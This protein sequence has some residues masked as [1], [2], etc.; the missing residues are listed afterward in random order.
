M[1]AMA[2]QDPAER[3]GGAV[4]G[5]AAQ[6]SAYEQATREQRRA[7]VI[8]SVSQAASTQARPGME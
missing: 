3:P 6:L 4:G 8:H 2:K 5:S 1:R 7:Q